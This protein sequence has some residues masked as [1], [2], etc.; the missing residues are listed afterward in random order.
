MALLVDLSKN[1]D[2][3]PYLE[4]KIHIQHTLLSL[5]FI[6]FNKPLFISPNMYKHFPI[7]NSKRLIIRE[8]KSTDVDIVFKFN[9]SKDCLKYIVRE[10]FQSK[11][12][13]IE[14]LN[15]FLEANKKKTAYWWVFTLK[16]TGEDIGY[17]GLFDISKEHNRAEIGYGIMQKHWNKGFMSEI[18]D[19]IIHFGKSS[20]S[21]HKIYAYIL[22]GNQVSIQLLEKRGF[23][24]EAHL[25]EHSF[26]NGK[27]WDET[28][29]SLINK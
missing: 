16:E 11:I 25:K 14:K 24:K 23:E 10:P 26:T 1:S 9:S 20:L 5:V 19:E 8:M 6:S 3:S 15:F 13:A 17:G 28:I 22:D 12:K 18:I 2:R 21:L 7:L 4:S 27:Y 29:Y